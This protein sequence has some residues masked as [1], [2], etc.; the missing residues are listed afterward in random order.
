MTVSKATKP[1]CQLL[2]FVI[3]KA[4]YNVYFHPLRSY[5]GP[6][7]SRA[8]RLHY[9]YHQL[10][11]DLPYQTKLWHDTYGETVRIAPDEL[12]YNSSRAYQDVHSWRSKEHR[13]GLEKDKTWYSQSINDVAVIVTAENQDHVRLRNVLSHAFSDHALARQEPL[14]RAYID[15]LM[16][17]LRGEAKARQKIDLVP[18]F[19]STAMDVILDLSFGRS[20]NCLE[21]TTGDGS[22]PWVHLVTGHVRQGLFVQAWRRLP[23]FVSRNIIANLALMVIGKQ[24]KKQFDVTTSM[25]R[26]RIARETERE[27]FVS[28]L[29]RE[30]NEKTGMTLPELELASSIFMTAGSDTNATL[31]CGT[32]Y[33]ILRDRAVWERLR[34]EIRSS[35]SQESNFSFRKL[36]VLPY[37]NA[38]IEEALRLYVVVP[39]T[40]PRRTPPEGATI[41]GKYVPGDFAVGVNGYAAAL[42]ETNFARAD[43]FHP[44]RWLVNTEAQF[45]RDDKKAHQPFSTGPRNCLGKNMAWAFARLAIARLVWNFD[46][47]LAPEC[48]DWH[49]GQ[50][51]FVM[52]VKKPLRV[53]L[54]QVSR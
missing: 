9:V 30:N 21:D 42:S 18:W 31:L 32:T 6:W 24:W 44:E 20:L 16:E 4:V 41:A 28:H 5:P 48:Q 26:E 46:A 19:T 54:K 23:A 11:G 38:V 17:K 34:D 10:I 45:K 43:E 25:T 14:I 2:F 50:D 27:D 8:T 22:H 53:S 37:L 40:F 12:S 35:F 47:E 49:E 3:A 15:L 51:I 33:F 7:L 13:S 29:L 1:L 36:Q 52:F 39:S